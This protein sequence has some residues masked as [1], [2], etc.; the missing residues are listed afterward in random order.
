[1]AATLSRNAGRKGKPYGAYKEGCKADVIF[2]LEDGS[3]RSYAPSRAGVTRETFRLW[4]KNDPEFARQVEIAEG[5]RTHH[6]K[7]K[8]EQAAAAPYKDRPDTKVLWKL[9]EASD[10]SYK[11]TADTEINIGHIGDNN[12][13]LSE[14]RMEAIRAL[15]A[16][17][18]EVK[19][20]VLADALKLETSSM[21]KLEKQNKEKKEKVISG[22][23]IPIS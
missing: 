16:Q 23:V 11:V 10:P 6:A 20:N 7:I 1:V 18:L 8:V 5:R 12:L 3:L 4:L 2:Y 19:S 13:I 17:A 9:L 21:P 15:K 22:T 14:A